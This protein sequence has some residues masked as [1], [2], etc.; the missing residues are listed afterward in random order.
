MPDGWARRSVTN[1]MSELL[2]PRRN[3]AWIFENRPRECLTRPKGN[4][5][6]GQFTG[7]MF[8]PF[9]SQAHKFLLSELQIWLGPDHWLTLVMRTET[10][11]KLAAKSARLQWGNSLSRGW[12]LVSAWPAAGSCRESQVTRGSFMGLTLVSGRELTGWS[13]CLV[14][15]S[16]ITD[17]TSVSLQDRLIRE[18][19]KL[20]PV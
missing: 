5:Y 4:R 14:V 12:M 16:G 10:F 3:A 13:K 18:R 9:P 15:R 2:H 19:E 20:R 1:E 7:S 6:Y 17:D 11:I 8:W